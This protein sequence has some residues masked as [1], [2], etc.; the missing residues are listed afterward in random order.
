MESIRGK[1]TQGAPAIGSAP[2]GS[3][4]GPQPGVIRHKQ[5]PGMRFKFR[6]GKP[7]VWAELRSEDRSKCPFCGIDVAYVTNLTTGERMPME[8][9]TAHKLNKHGKVMGI[10]HI[11]RCRANKEWRAL[12]LKERKHSFGKK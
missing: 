8:L 10:G 11:G 1:L 6:L 7:T 5:V 4:A 9:K 12:R 2:A 3:V